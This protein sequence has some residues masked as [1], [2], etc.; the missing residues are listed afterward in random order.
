MLAHDV[1]MRND[2]ERMIVDRKLINLVKALY[3]NPCYR[4]EI[5]GKGSSVAASFA[6]FRVTK[7]TRE[8]GS[9]RDIE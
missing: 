6:V 5:E 9:L 7:G 4:V 1:D 3:A 8:G 2:T